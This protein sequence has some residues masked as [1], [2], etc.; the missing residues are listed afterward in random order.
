MRTGTCNIRLIS[1]ATFFLL[2]WLAMSCEKTDCQPTENQEI[3]VKA[4]SDGLTKAGTPIFPATFGLYANYTTA[5]DGTNCKTVWDTSMDKYLDNNCFANID[6]KTTYANVNPQ[7]IT[8]HQPIYWPNTGSLM[9]TAYAPHISQNT[10]IKS[11]RYLRYA[12]P[13]N[14]SRMEINVVL[15]EKSAGQKETATIQLTDGSSP[16]DLLWVDTQ[17]IN[18]NRS[19]GRQAHPVPLKFRHAMSKVTVKITNPEA[20]YKATVKLLHCINA[21]T[22]YS[23]V[24]PGWKPDFSDMENGMVNYVLFDDTTLDDS[25]QASS[26][27]TIPAKLDAQYQEAPL[28]FSEPVVLRVRLSSKDG[29]GTETKDF[30]LSDYTTIWKPNKHY[31]YSLTIHSQKIEF[32]EPIIENREQIIEP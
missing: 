11:I 26:V 13:T 31:I 9:F 17:H 27:C 10:C 18:G 5:S 28:N 6:G 14:Q 3:S 22:F 25:T 24:T 19:I 7:N 12:K 30:V 4:F 8:E 23:G 15:K 32:G 16:L 21:A 2:L 20:Q 1:L 29:V